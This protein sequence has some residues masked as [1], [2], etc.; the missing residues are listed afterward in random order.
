V[1]A[2]LAGYE[3]AQQSEELV[4]G[5]FIRVTLTMVKKEGAAALP[6]ALAPP[7]ASGSALPPRLP[8]V[9]KEATGPRKEVLIGGGV[10]AGAALIAGVVL[11]VMSSSKAA[12]A[13]ERMA[14]LRQL[15]DPDPCLRHAGDCDAIEAARSSHDTLIGG[16]R[17]SFIGAG[18]LT[19]ATVAYGLLSRS[20]RSA[21]RVRVLPMI[22]VGQ[23]GLAVWGAW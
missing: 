17:V 15:G 11:A 12:D 21:G 9:E 1:E 4:K 22:T 13:D 10:T 7:T 20:P 18:A 2:K 16:A 3:A 8:P 14:K 19:A 6:P 5:E 23:A